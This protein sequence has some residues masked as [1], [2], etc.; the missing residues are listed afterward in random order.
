MSTTLIDEITVVLN[1][2]KETGKVDLSLAKN[3]DALATVFK[4]SQEK[5]LM[6]RNTKVN[7]YFYYAARNAALVVSRMKERF[8]SLNEGDVN[9]KIADESLQVV[10][11]IRELL[12]FVRQEKPD[13][14]VTKVIIERV[15]QLRALA[16]NAKLVQTQE[17]EL[18]DVD[19]LLGYMSKLKR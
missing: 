12:D 10:G 9:A 11:L 17:K 13:E 2:M 7:I 4:E 19:K 6:S 18:E 14:G 3:L 16:T 1:N 5:W 8:L 15:K